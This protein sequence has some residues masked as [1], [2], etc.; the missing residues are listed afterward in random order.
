MATTKQ[1]KKNTT[2]S[3]EEKIQGWRQEQFQRLLPGISDADIAA[4]VSSS[5]SPHELKKLQ[6][7]GCPSE[8][9]VEILR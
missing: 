5:S 3:E 1:Q 7:N 9:A 4:L 2:P 8:V 6:E